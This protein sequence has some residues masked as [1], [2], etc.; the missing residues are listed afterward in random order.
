MLLNCSEDEEPSPVEL[1]SP[2]QLM[3]KKHVAY[4]MDISE[5]P[6]FFEAPTHEQSQMCSHPDLRVHLRT[7]CLSRRVSWHVL[8]VGFLETHLW[9]LPSWRLDNRH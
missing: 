6:F 3:R 8:N 7:V 5:T 2:T 9:R 1:V 4:Q